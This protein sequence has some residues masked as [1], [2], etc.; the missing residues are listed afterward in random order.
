MTLEEQ[1]RLALASGQQVE[2]TPANAVNV[3]VSLN[4]DGSVA[5]PAPT[6][7]QQPQVTYQQPA[8]QVDNSPM[9]AQIQAQMAL[10]SQELAYQR[11]LMEQRQNEASNRQ[12]VKPF[13]DPETD[14]LT[15]D[16]IAGF[17]ESMPVI[18]KLAKRV[19]AEALQQSQQ[20]IQQLYQELNH[21]RGQLEGVHRQAAVAN[22]TALMNT[23][24]SAVPD[25]PHIVNSPE[26]RA[27]L[28]ERARFGGGRSV[29]QAITEAISQN[30]ASLLVD[31]LAEFKSRNGGQLQQRPVQVPQAGRASAPTSVGLNIPAPRQ[32]ISMAAIDD[33][34]AKVQAGTLSKE[35]YDR[36]LEQ[37]YA[38]AASGLSVVQ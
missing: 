27:Y 11:S 20:Q 17:K 21:T 34:M 3:V 32:G 31:H 29:A 37:T 8:P 35:V 5:A 24:T 36:M 12:V 7:N 16:E 18:N 4:E 25:A 15:P 28:T 38:A 2:A 30:N 10:Q 22:E 1:M 19:A 14:A 33:A 13:Y 9:F 6:I 26:W 23:V